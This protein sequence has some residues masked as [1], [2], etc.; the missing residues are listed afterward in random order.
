TPCRVTA[1]AR[2]AL[3]CGQI[4]YMLPDGSA[5]SLGRSVRNPDQDAH[6]RRPGHASRRKTQLTLFVD[7]L[8][9][10]GRPAAA[11]AGTLPTRLQRSVRSGTGCPA[12]SGS[13][14]F[15]RHRLSPRPLA[16][17]CLG[18]RPCFGRGRRLRHIRSHIFGTGVPP[19]SARSA[20]P[21]GVGKKSWSLAPAGGDFRG[22]CGTARI[23]YLP[24]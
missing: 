22:P 8:P 12:R 9:S 19:S 4:R 5:L 13:P 3:V 15:L 7:G 23:H 11:R 6:S 16:S 10:V 20:P 24:R 2:P 21:S 17:V 14:M 18:R 1:R